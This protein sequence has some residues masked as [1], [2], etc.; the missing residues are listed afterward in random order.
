MAPTRLWLTLIARA[1]WGN[2]RFDQMQKYAQEEGRHTTETWVAIVKR[3]KQASRAM[4]KLTAVHRL[5][6]L[7]VW[8][9][10]KALMGKAIAAV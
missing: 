2:A 7:R 1:K 3:A 10:M 5:L 8:H 6:T 9:R 4:K